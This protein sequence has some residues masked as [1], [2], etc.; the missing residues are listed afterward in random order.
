MFRNSPAMKFAIPF[1]LGIAAGYRLRL[2]IGVSTA[3]AGA[4]IIPGIVAA[5]RFPQART[6]LL[7]VLIVA[8]GMITI[9]ADLAIVPPDRIERLLPP[10]PADSPAEG[11]H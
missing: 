1:V 10:A 2:P 5:S 8:F 6:G 3:I 4:A 11:A 9:N 7:F